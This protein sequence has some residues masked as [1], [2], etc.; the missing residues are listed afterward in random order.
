M[1]AVFLL[2]K[3]KA[4]TPEDVHNAWV[5]WM[6][7]RGEEHESMVPFAELPL[8]PQDEDLAVCPCDS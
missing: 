7:F 8:G 4:V 5:A 3:G 6:A 2:A 1:H